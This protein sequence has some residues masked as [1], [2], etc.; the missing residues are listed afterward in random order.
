MSSTPSSSFFTPGLARQ[1]TLQ[2]RAH[3]MRFHPTPSEALL[4]SQLR[5]RRLGVQFRRQV[6]VGSHIID[7]MA[8]AAALVVE[9][10]GDGYH[11]GRAFA[12]RCRDAKL[13]R[14]GYVVLRLP[15]SLV[16]RRLG[17][18]VALVRAAL[19]G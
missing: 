9:V 8:P 17:E 11:A 10:D 13:R 3:F 16:E 5:G 6:I 2:Q 7:F 15:A 14:A 18:A 12:D 19:G 1:V 4:W